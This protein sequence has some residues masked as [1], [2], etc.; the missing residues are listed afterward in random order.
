MG[1]RG[2]HPVK[3]TMQASWEREV[4]KLPS[5]G[6]REMSIHDKN[7]CP[8]VPCWPSVPLWQLEVPKIDLEVLGIES[9]NPES[10]LVREFQC[11]IIERYQDHIL[12]FTEQLLVFR[13]GTPKLLRDLKFHK[14]VHSG[15]IC[16][17]D[18]SG[19]D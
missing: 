17:P 9:D 14:C 2:D 19:M 11:H 4:A 13:D 16:S 18:G 15:T 10:Y 1:P 3:I 5:V 6:W 7:F 8:G 12:M